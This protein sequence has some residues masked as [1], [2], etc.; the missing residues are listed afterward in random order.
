M[1]TL[2]SEKL[3]ERH[4]YRNLGIDGR[5]LLVLWISKEQDESII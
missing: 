3:K 5:I 1:Q 4:H 2:K